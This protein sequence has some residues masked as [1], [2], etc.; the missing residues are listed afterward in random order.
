[1]PAQSGSDQMLR[2][3]RRGYMGGLPLAHRSLLSYLMSLY[4]RISLRAFVGS[5]RG[6]FGT[7]SLIEDGVNGLPVRVFLARADAGGA[8]SG[9]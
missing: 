4:R 1:M 6:S 9:G 2:R 5:L 3:M 8:A 7:L